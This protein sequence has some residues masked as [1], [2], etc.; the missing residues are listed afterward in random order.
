V[1]V[2]E[3]RFATAAAAANPVSAQAHA[4]LADSFL[5]VTVRSGAVTEGTWPRPAW[6]FD[7]EWIDAE[8]LND[9]IAEYREAIRLDPTLWYVRR[10]LGNVLVFKGEIE[11]ALVE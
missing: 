10:H 11:N 4:S 5:L 9:A 2:D 1:D 7:P 6:G 3:R 8:D